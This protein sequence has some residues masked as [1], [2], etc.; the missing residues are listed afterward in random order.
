MSRKN[1]ICFSVIGILLLISL[2]VTYATNDKSTTQHASETQMKEFEDAKE[3]NYEIKPFKYLIKSED[4]LL[5]VYKDNGQTV[6]IKTTIP[7]DVLSD[8]LKEELDSGIKFENESDLYSFLE[9]YS[10]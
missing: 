1:S 9:S 8:K 6:F 7:I 3:I 4:N 10:S 5:V 2:F